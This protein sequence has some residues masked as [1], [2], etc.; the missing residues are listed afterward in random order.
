MCGLP[1]LAVRAGLQRL[2]G[3]VLTRK[4]ALPRLR[5][6]PARRFIDEATRQPRR[7][8]GLHQTTTAH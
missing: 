5:H 3:T 7:V 6:R 2:H 8:H 4:A 1:Q